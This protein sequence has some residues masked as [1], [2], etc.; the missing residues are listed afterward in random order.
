M[1]AKKAQ[2]PFIMLLN[3]DT[4]IQPGS[5]EALLQFAATQPDA[6]AFGGLTL[7]PAHEPD[8]SNRLAAPSLAGLARTAFAFAAPAR[9]ADARLPTAPRRV[10]ILCG[11]FMLIRAS[12]WQQLGGFD[13][14]FFLYSEEVDLFHRLAEQNVPAWQIPAAR[15]VHAVGNGNPHAPLRLVLRAAGQAEFLRKHWS[16]PKRVLGTMLMWLAAIGRFLG[17]SV[18]KY[19]KPQ[20]GSLAR[21]YRLMAVKPWLWMHGY[22]PTKGLK[23]KLATLQDHG[24]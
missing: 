7:T 6:G 17:G 23:A 3:P 8:P 20:L 21:G 10:P 18:L 11:G 9:P 15:A 19:W 24:S 22:H 13:E 2:A 14:R 16:A 5:I 4:I 1:L 12:A